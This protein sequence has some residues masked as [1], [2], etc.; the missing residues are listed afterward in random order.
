M[1]PHASHGI[2]AAVSS[3]WDSSDGARTKP[4]PSQ[5]LHRVEFASGAIPETLIRGFV[6]QTPRAGDWCSKRAMGLEPTT[7]SLGS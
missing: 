5:S 3:A 4:A 1:P 6:H 7:L 2:I